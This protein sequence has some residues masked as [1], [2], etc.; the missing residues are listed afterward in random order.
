VV[1]RSG[2][3]PSTNRPTPGRAHTSAHIFTARGPPAALR[4]RP[5]V[6]IDA[7]SSLSGRPTPS[8]T[9]SSTNSGLKDSRCDLALGIELRPATLRTQKRDCRSTTPLGERPLRCATLSRAF[10]LIEAPRDA[11]P[12]V[13]ACGVWRL[14]S[15]LICMARCPDELHGRVVVANRTRTALQPRSAAHRRAIVEPELELESLD[16][17]AVLAAIRADSEHS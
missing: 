9:L 4:L 1:S 12:G 6:A 17:A 13:R 2:F 16:A 11:A 14:A 15:T 8:A 5:R 3:H 10:R 7:P